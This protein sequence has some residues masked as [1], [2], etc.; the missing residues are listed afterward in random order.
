[1]KQIQ[2]KDKIA[3]RIAYQVLRS[4]LLARGINPGDYLKLYIQDRQVLVSDIPFNGSLDRL[5]ADGLPEGNFKV[6]EYDYSDN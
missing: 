3:A 1:M 2:T 5:V 4:N 6:R